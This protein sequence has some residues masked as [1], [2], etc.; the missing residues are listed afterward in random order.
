M[1]IALTGYAQSGKS[2]AVRMIR[3]MRPWFKQSNFKDG[4]IA[5]MKHYFPKVLTK[6]SE[7]HS[8]TMKELFD[9][10]PGIMRELMQNFGTELRRSENANYWTDKWEESI[11]G[12]KDVLVDDCRFLNEAEV[13]RRNGGVIVRMVRT[14]MTNNSTHQSETEMD[15]IVPDYTITT[16]GSEF[17][18]IEE[19]LS[20]ILIL[21]DE[22]LTK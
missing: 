14:D 8:M 6:L 10:K 2:T 21:E 22:K 19:E 12:I 5:E 18:K 13:V 9:K 4:L 3:E 17:R 7:E 1:I 16:N 15:L 11:K 20:R